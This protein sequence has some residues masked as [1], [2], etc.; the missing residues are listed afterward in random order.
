MRSRSCYC[1]LSTRTVIVLYC[2]RNISICGEYIIAQFCKHIRTSVLRH[3]LCSCWLMRAAAN[4][5]VDVYMFRSFVAVFVLRRSRCRWFICGIWS[6]SVDA[7]RSTAASTTLA[8]RHRICP[9]NGVRRQFCLRK[10]LLSHS[11]L[12]LAFFGSLNFLHITYSGVMCS[13]NDSIL[14]YVVFLNPCF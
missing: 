9:R 12:L 8:N 4:T 3:V 2:G 6:T 10:Q 11:V 13:L 5:F 14:K 1:R 7:R